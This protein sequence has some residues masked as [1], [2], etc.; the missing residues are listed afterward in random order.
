MAGSQLHYKLREQERRRK[1][2]AKRLRRQER[3]ANKRSSVTEL[4]PTN[5]RADDASVK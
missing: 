2:D 4:Q 5:Q 1:A 3:R